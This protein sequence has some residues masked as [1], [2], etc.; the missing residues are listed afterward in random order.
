[1]SAG[2]H[3][4]LNSPGFNPNKMSGERL[5]KMKALAQKALTT[6]PPKLN[7]PHEGP[8]STPNGDKMLE[9][10][11]WAN[12]NRAKAPRDS[13]STGQF[14]PGWPTAKELDD[15]VG[16]PDGFFTL[17]GLHYCNLFANPRMNVLFNADSDSQACAMDHGKR[18]AATLLD[19]TLGTRYFASLGRGFSGAFSVMGTHSKAKKCPFRPKSE[20][21]EMPK[22]HR[23]ANRRFTTDQR[24]SWVGSHMAA[25]AECGASEAFQTKYGL[26]LAMLVSAYAPFVD[27]KTG[28]LDWME[29]T[30]YG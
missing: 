5:E 10:G 30:A 19:E 23:K 25:A 24:D 22:G 29:E 18:I 6:F 20:Q 1:M 4:A 16:G 15:E 2:K 7:G 11:R 26:W 28:K 13:G 12:A 8:V 9:R 3:E 27:E 21:V 14:G 17:C